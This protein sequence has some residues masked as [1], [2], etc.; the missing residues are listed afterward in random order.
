[1]T[2]PLALRPFSNNLVAVPGNSAAF[3]AAEQLEAMRLKAFHN[4]A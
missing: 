1:M 3:S 4:A 2:T